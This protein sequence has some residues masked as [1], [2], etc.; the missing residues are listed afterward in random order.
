[1]CT[2]YQ[3]NSKKLYLSAVKKIIRY[4]IK[5]YTVSLWY[6]KNFSIDLI[7]Y[8]NADFTYCKLDRKSIS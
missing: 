8:S 4:L 2:R 6:S 7:V 3:A 5:I 1:M